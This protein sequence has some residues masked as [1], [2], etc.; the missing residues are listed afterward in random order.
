MNNQQPSI[1]SLEDKGST[2]IETTV[3]IT[4]KGVEYSKINTGKGGDL[5]YTIKIYAL[6]D[7]NNGHIRYVGKAKNVNTR[8]YGHLHDKKPSYKT[9]W[10][11][12]LKGKLPEVFI[13]DEVL[14][15]DWIFW[16]KYWISQVKSWGFK[17]TNM[18]LGGEGHEGFKQSEETKTLRASKLKGQKR[19]L[20][21]RNN[22]SVARKG[23]KFTEEHLNNLSIS[24]KGKIYPK[25]NYGKHQFKKVYQILDDKIIKEWD[26]VK[27]ASLFY[28]VHQS[29]I[30]HSCAGKFKTK[31]FNWKYC[32]DYDIV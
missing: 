13:L 3:E 26:S 30:A 24:H 25:G 23:I 6:I 7:P 14:K 31:G 17:L 22:Q 16:E 11:K 28:N 10:I 5:N 12:S 18:T 32:S 1:L 8:I 29:C 4:G 9:N 19:T 21:Q 15:E 2:T 20:E 27:E